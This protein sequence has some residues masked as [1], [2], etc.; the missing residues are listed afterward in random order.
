[1]P[2]FLAPLRTWN[3]HAQRRLAHHQ[4]PHA[5]A[6]RFAREPG[7]Y[8]EAVDVP[9]QRG[10]RLGVG[11]RACALRGCVCGEGLSGLASLSVS[12]ARDAT[13]C[14]AQIRHTRTDRQAQFRQADLQRGR[15]RGAARRFRGVARAAGQVDAEAVTAAIRGA[16]LLVVDG[17]VAVGQQGVRE[18]LRER[19]C[20]LV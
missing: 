2:L 9:N 13:A 8:E 4:P 12:L 20:I 3:C 17:Q 6:G 19:A 10:N 15:P 1:M 7:L 5:R 11:R 16:R 18:R 14:I